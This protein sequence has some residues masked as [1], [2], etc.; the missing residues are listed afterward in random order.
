[1]HCSCAMISP[2]DTSSKKKKEEPTWMESNGMERNGRKELL[3]PTAA[4][5]AGPRYV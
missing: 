3:N 5:E 4:T 2:R 1:M